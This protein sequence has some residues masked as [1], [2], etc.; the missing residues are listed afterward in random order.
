MIYKVFLPYQKETRHNLA[1]KPFRWLCWKNA[2]NNL[3][4]TFHFEHSNKGDGGSEIIFK[5]KED[6]QLFILMWGEYLG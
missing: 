5:E 3:K 1:D 4:G 6:M 2:E